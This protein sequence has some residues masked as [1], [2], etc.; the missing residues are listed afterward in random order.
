M[1]ASRLISFLLII[2]PTVMLGRVNM[3]P[4][5]NDGM[6]LQQNSRVKLWGWTKPN[7][8]VSLKG[9]WNGKRVKT[10]ADENGRFEAILETQAGNFI[11]QTIEVNDGD[12]LIIRDV[13]IGEVWLCSGQ[14][15]MEMPLHGFG[16]CPVENSAEYIAEAGKYSGKLHLNFV[17][18]SPSP[19]PAET[20][21]ALWQDCTPLSARDFCAIGYFFG[22]RLVETLNVP[23]G[24]INSSL[25][26]TRVEGWTPREITEKYPGENLESD[27]VKNCNKVKP[28]RN[29]ERSLPTV[30]YNG[31]IHPLEGYTLKGF[32]WYQGEANVNDPN[33]YCDRFINMVQAWRDRWGQGVLPFYYVE[34]CPYD[35]FWAKNKQTAPLLREAQYKAQNMIPNMGM[36]CTNDLVKDY[37]YWAIHPCMK[38]EVG[39]RLCYWALG[40]TYCIAGID[41]RYPEYQSM[42]VKGDQVILTFKNAE[43]GF[44]RRVGIEGFEVAGS[45]SVW[46]KATDIRVYDEEKV[47]VKCTDVKEPIAVRYCFQSWLL[48]NLKGN[49]GLP[50]IPFRTDNWPL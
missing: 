25:G 9:S 35:Y 46:H 44:S 36:V 34:I 4:L 6:V 29:V 48:G 50:I 19:E 49:S 14:S 47:T 3:G 13:L 12:K 31:M 21:T 24:I 2:W 7:H 18:W 32:L 33:N 38:K 28:G 26:A 1:K 5:Q 37:E 39:D 43:S 30:F 15:N 17:S 10:M 22:I 41:F 27:A 40:Q 11:P 16:S 45:D 23:V 42:E 8:K 20:V